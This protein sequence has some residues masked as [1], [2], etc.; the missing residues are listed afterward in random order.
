[1]ERQNLEQSAVNDLQ[2]QIAVYK[3]QIETLQR[4][5]KK[6][7]TPMPTLNKTNHL[8]GCVLIASGAG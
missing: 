6:V 5:K 7:C 2:Q 1:M 4:D 8:R 3:A